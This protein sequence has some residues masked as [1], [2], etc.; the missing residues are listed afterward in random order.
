VQQGVLP[1]P[2]FNLHP[3]LRTILERRVQSVEKSA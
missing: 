3:Q 1:P 2:D